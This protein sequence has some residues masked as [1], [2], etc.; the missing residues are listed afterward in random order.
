M[1]ATRAKLKVI[2]SSEMAENDARPMLLRLSGGRTPV[3]SSGDSFS[4][5]QMYCVL[6]WAAPHDISHMPITTEAMIPTVAAVMARDCISSTP[7]EA[8][9][10][11]MAA[12]VPWP[13]QKPA[14]MERP[15]E[16]STGQK[17]LRTQRPSAPP[18]AHCSSIPACE[19]AHIRPIRAL[20]S[21]L[22]ALPEVIGIQLNTNAISIPA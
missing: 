20:P 3:R 9:D 14:G 7:Y 19:Y 11:P 1:R 4:K 15:N 8:K 10:S 6:P 18:S 21:L 5:A 16:G 13:P 12:A 22:L 2:E 17:R